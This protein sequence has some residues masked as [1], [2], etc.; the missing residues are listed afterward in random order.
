MPSPAPE[1]P[2]PPP[3]VGV[4]LVFYGLLAGAAAVWDS[5]R[6]GPTDLLPGPDAATVPVSVT[7][8]LALAAAVVGTSRALE[9][10][11]RWAQQI[12]TELA[13]RLGPLTTAEIA[14]FS[15]ASG[16]AE[17]LF[18]RGAMQPTLGL[19]VT[20][21]IFGVAHGYF[22]RRFLAWMAMATVV[23]LALGALASFTGSLLGPILAHF[24]VNYFEL[25]A[26]DRVARRRAGA[27]EE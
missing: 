14:V 8:A 11:F 25:H 26:L 15:G 10:R 2:P 24:T 4:T 21:L 6:A 7:L 17:E 3:S 1:S 5:V 27:G 18:F 20:S 19:W 16:V 22:D 23:G 13:R 12:T 9:R